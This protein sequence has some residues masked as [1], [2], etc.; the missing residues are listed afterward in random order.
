MYVWIWRHL[1]GGTGVRAVTALALA[2]AVAVLLLFV[3]FPAV[4]SHVEL[5]TPAL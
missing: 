4:S 5:W 2:L 3:V 1:P